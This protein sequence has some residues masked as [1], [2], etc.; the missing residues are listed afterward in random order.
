MAL[1]WQQFLA[2]FS[3]ESY[4][5]LLAEVGVI[6]TLITA[7]AAWNYIKEYKFW[8]YIL[9]LIYLISTVVV[10]LTTDWFFFLFAWEMVT[11][12]TTFLLA[13]SSWK[14]VKQYFVIQ[15]TGSSILLFAALAANALGY[16]E[17]AAI[18]SVLLQFVLII[19]MAT[20]SGI[21]IFHFWL[22]PIHSEAPSPVS[23]ILS[24]WV[25][26]L[27]YIFLLKIIPIESGNTMLYLLGIAMVVYGGWQAV[28][29][30]DLKIMLAY[31]TVSQLGFIALAIGT[32][33]ELAF[34]GAVLFIIAHG[35]AKTTLFITSGILQREYGSR[36]VYDFK[37]A[38]FKRPLTSLAVIISFLSLA[39]LVFS[40]GYNAK[41]LISSA[42]LPGL[43][44]KVVFF[45]FALISAI[46]SLRILYW[47]FI[48]DEDYSN[49][50]D[51]LKKALNSYQI[52]STDILAIL[53]GTLGVLIVAFWPEMPGDML[54][55]LVDYDFNIIAG[56]RDSII[57]ILLAVYLIHNNAGFKVKAR[58]HLSLERYLRSALDF[59]FSMSRKN[60]KFDTDKIFETVFYNT[61]FNT[62]KKIHDF[63]YQD[64]TIQL[65]WIP[66]FLSILLLWQQIYSYF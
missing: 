33:G 24:G 18:D 32:G 47:I 12:T 9:T 58:D 51:K 37:G 50:A 62:S 55:Y 31:S 7:L 2:S 1:L 34:L 11:L 61:I 23:A 20:K 43:L 29:S 25:V 27:G 57:Y 19:G 10:I 54:E 38:I 56:V 66:V 3:F 59:I 36:V 21:F 15:F 26:K 44:T 35:F 30:A 65:L 6:L 63:F 5:P 46:Y 22:P 48:V 39:G 60:V 16:T 13:W 17:I 28:R 49:F 64:L 14:L 8:Y 4:F 40:A 45:G 42:Q 53:F 41:Y 52:Y